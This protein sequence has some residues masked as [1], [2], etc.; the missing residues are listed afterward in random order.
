[1]RVTLS[2]SNQKRVS[3]DLPENIAHAVFL[4]ASD[5]VL[6][7]KNTEE[8]WKSEMI[9]RD[10]HRT[11]ESSANAIAKLKVG[12][13]EEEDKEIVIV[14]DAFPDRLNENHGE[15][16]LTEAEPKTYVERPRLIFYICEHCGALQHPIGKGG[17]VTYCRECNGMHII[18]NTK[19]AEYQCPKCNTGASFRVEEGVTVVG[20]KNCRAN[21][22]LIQHPGANKLVS[23]N[24]LRY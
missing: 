6:G 2:M 23:A 7:K 10:R 4:K 8:L 20:C 22:D 13:T 12:P 3:V 16:E 14:K 19:Y 1:M 24:M 9:L 17:D 11:I 18:A 5:I 15:A 21:I